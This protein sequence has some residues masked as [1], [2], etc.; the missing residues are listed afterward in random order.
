MFILCLIL[1]VFI[2]TILCILY[3]YPVCYDSFLTIKKIHILGQSWILEL[4]PQNMNISYSHTV[5]NHYFMRSKN[6]TLSI[7]HVISS[8]YK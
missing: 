2:Y 1:Y 5:L 6:V 4:P 8:Y 7:V 3:A